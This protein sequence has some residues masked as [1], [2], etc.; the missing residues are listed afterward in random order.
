MILLILN[1]KM[2]SFLMLIQDAIVTTIATVN[3]T[4]A[5][6]ILRLFNA[7]KR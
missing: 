2:I 7:N 4:A 1:S 6:H 5:V 3:S